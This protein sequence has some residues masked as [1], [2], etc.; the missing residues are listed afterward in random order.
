MAVPFCLLLV[1][2]CSKES[3]IERRIY[4]KEG[5]WNVDKYTT[6]EYENGAVTATGSIYDAG[7]FVFEKNGVFA[8]VIPIFPQN[9]SGLWS[10]T[11]DEVI[12][13]FENNGY[14]F[15]ISGESR[16]EM[17]LESTQVYSDSTKGVIT[18]KMS[19][20]K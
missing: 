4:S 2:A 3:R 9:T 6:T 8:S 18:M 10:S 17:T 20:H 16:R 13:I 12:L 15:K 11:E 1:T 7:Y 5:K 19:K 14:P